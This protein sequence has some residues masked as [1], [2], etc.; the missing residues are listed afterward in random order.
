VRLHLCERCGGLLLLL[1]QSLHDGLML[2]SASTARLHL[3]NQTQ[4]ACTFTIDVIA[5]LYK[6][7]Q[8]ALLGLGGDELCAQCLQMFARSR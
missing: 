3:A 5:A 4:Q 1:E 8:H 6:R 7:L 2:R